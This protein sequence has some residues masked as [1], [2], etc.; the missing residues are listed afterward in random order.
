MNGY[1]LDS[2]TTDLISHVP[3]VYRETPLGYLIHPRKALWPTWLE[4]YTE[5][6][7]WE[8]YYTHTLEVYHEWHLLDNLGERPDYMISSYHLSL[9]IWPIA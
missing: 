5:N 1:A 3:C 7:I 6:N 2:T 4:P 9:L 8:D